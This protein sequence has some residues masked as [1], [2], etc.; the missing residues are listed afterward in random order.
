MRTYEASPGEDINTTAQRMVAMA[1]HFGEVVTSTFNEIP[2]DA[3]PNG[4]PQ[5]IADGYMAELKRRSDEYH[6]STEYAQRQQEAQA[7]QQRKERDQAIALAA[8]PATLTL[9]NAEGWQKAVEVNKGDPYS[10]AVI[11]FAEKWARIMEGKMAAGE[12][13]A[14]CAD[15]ACSLADDDGITGFMYGAAVSTLAQT[16]VHGDELRRWH[17]RKYMTE[18]RAAKADETGGVV[19]PAILTIG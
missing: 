14:Q 1:T 19:N 8:A 13:L 9:R 3:A 2:L 17:N 15:A 5:A 6:A 11:V 10:N 7:A 12:S 16:W 18:E 4:D